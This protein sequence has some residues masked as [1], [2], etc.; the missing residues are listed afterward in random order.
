MTHRVPA[1]GWSMLPSILPGAVLRVEPIDVHAVSVGMIICYLEESKLAVAHRVIRVDDGGKERVFATQ[2]D[3]QTTYRRVPAHAVSGVVR[4]IEQ[5][6]VSYDTD[7]PI[8]R[9]FSTAATAEGLGWRAVRGIGRV[10]FHISARLAARANGSRR[11]RPD[12]VESK[13][14][15]P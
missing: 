5:P 10:V 13:R 4:R 7:G 3:V 2:G 8:G 6:F 9:F 11:D 14:P 12:N 1:F 15:A